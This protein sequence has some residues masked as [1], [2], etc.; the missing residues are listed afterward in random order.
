MGLT[1]TDRR[2]RLFPILLL[3][4]AL[5]L[6]LGGA[7]LASLGGSLYYLPAGLAII[8]SAVLLWGGKASTALLLPETS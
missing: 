7:Q 1:R 5:P 2:P 6:V 8:V 4:V 3:L